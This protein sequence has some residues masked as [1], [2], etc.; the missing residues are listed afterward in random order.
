MG[1]HAL[2]I[3]EFLPLLTNQGVTMTQT[4]PHSLLLAT[5]LQHMS[6]SKSINYS[7][8]DV[9]SP[10]NTYGPMSSSSE[11]ISTVA[12]F[13]DVSADPFFELDSITL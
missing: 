11:E 2:L 1:D 3:K 10:S 5:T 4:L 6:D 13:Y 9:Y 8:N 7:S 12:E